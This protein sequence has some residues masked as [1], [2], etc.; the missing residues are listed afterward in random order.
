MI[1]MI[2]V[3]KNLKYESYSLLKTNP[4]YSQDLN[5]QPGGDRRLWREN[6]P[7]V[8]EILIDL[9]TDSVFPA[10][11]YDP[12][13]LG[14]KPLLIVLNDICENH[15]M[16]MAQPF[17]QWSVKNRWIFIHPQYFSCKQGKGTTIDQIAQ[18]IHQ[19]IQYAKRHAD[20]DC[21][22]IYIAGFRSGGKAALHTAGLFSET[23]TAVSV[24]STGSEYIEGIIHNEDTSVL[25]R[26]LNSGNGLEQLKKNVS[27]GRV[28]VYI[29]HGIEDSSN[30]AVYAVQI[31]EELYGSE[32]LTRLQRRNLFKGEQN[33]FSQF[34]EDTLYNHAGIDVLLQKE[35]NNLKFSLFQGKADIVYNASLC[36]MAQQR[37]E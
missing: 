3:F 15:L 30:S 10:L 1:V 13:G 20:V 27:E 34:H 2:S 28:G 32:I 18:N 8:Q 19:I 31:F 14:A 17:A 33:R 23:I 26:S 29:A 36:W 16:S 21:S 35:R 6:L 7:Q 11:W 22:R 5:K 4:V 9:E 25:S 12:K 24:W 37:S